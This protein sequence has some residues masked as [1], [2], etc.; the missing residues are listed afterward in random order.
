[1]GLTKQDAVAVLVTLLAYR[2]KIPLAKKPHTALQAENISREY[3]KTFTFRDTCHLK[4][5]NFI[6]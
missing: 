1:M 6:K 4:I 5:K 3:P 2:L